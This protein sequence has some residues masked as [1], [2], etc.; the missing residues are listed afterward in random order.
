[1]EEETEEKLQQQAE[2][3]QEKIQLDRLEDGEFSLLKK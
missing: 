3:L 2:A 1:M